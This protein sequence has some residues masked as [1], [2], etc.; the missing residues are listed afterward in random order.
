VV[1]RHRA[2][3]RLERPLRALELGSR[4]AEVIVESLRDRER[5][6]I[7]RRRREDLVVGAG[8]C[9]EVAVERGGDGGG[10]A[11]SCGVSSR[12]LSLA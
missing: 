4:V 6:Q 2:P 1:S 12:A 8:G 11:S 5:Q 3:P 9:G 7:V 10:W